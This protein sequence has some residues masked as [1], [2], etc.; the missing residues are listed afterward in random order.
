[1]AMTCAR[2]GL[3]AGEVVACFRRVGW[4]VIY[5]RLHARGTRLG[6][7]QAEGHGQCLERAAR[8]FFSMRTIAESSSCPRPSLAR[9][10]GRSDRAAHLPP[11]G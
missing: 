8:R 4:H 2:G 9:R 3:S 11:R 5:A 7:R 1:M 6:R 10:F